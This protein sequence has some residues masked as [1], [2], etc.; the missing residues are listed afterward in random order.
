MMYGYP[1]SNWISASVWKNWRA[2]IFFFEIALVLDHLVVVLGHVD[3]G[4]RLA[5]DALDIVG[6]EQVH[7]LVLLSQLERHIRNNDAE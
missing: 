5:V 6:R 1:D 4:E 2:L 3:V 7:V